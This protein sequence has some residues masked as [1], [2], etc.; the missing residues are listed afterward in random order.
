[1]LITMSTYYLT[2]MTEDVSEKLKI[3]TAKEK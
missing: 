3:D 2:E 1:M